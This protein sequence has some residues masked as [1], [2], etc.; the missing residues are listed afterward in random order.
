MLERSLYFVFQNMQRLQVYTNLLQ[1][2]NLVTRTRMLKFV[3]CVCL[4]VV[5]DS[6]LQQVCKNFITLKGLQ[7]KFIS[8]L[9]SK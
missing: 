8:K 4:L 7:K 1:E 5:M 2:V 3:A 6:K 9:R